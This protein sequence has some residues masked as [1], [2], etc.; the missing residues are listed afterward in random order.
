M[1]NFWKT[2]RT[3]SVALKI[4]TVILFVFF[5]SKLVYIFLNFSS[6]NLASLLCSFGTSTYVCYH[7]LPCFIWQVLQKTNIPLFSHLKGLPAPV[8]NVV[9]TISSGCTT[10]TV[11]R[12]KTLVALCFCPFVF[13]IKLYT[14]LLHV[15]SLQGICNARPDSHTYCLAIVK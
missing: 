7:L 8:V 13:C 1:H 10:V 5:L 6:Q 2:C 11:C 14:G 15:L 3:H 9:N 12:V 4:R